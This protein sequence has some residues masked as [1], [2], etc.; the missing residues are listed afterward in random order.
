MTRWIARNSWTLK[1]CCMIRIR[2]AV[3]SSPRALEI[4]QDFNDAVVG[5]SIDTMKLLGIVIDLDL[6]KTLE[7]AYYR[8]KIL[9]ENNI[10]NLQSLT[11]SQ[12][13]V[14]YG[15]PGEIQFKCKDWFRD[16]WIIW[17]PEARKLRVPYLLNRD[18][19]EEFKRNFLDD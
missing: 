6:R 19:F 11:G 9:M 15:R 1:I 16:F 14:T 4:L 3:Q 8:N 5:V 17:E 2:T 12:V 10:Y 7:I 18:G 13:K